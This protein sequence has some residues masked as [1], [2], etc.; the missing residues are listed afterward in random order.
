MSRLSLKPVATGVA[1]LCVT[2][3]NKRSL[4]TNTQI[5]DHNIG[6]ILGGASGRTAKDEE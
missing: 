5:R 4:R 6:L 1:V 3:T 2:V